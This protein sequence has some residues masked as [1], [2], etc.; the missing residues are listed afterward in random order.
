[1]M[2]TTARL[3]K[4]GK[5]A[6][7][8]LW[9]ETHDEAAFYVATGQTR[10]GERGEALFAGRK[11]TQQPGISANNVK[12]EVNPQI[13]TEAFD[14]SQSYFS[15]L[16]NFQ[17]N[18]NADFE[19]EFGRFA[20]SQNIA[21]GSQAWRRK[22]TDAIRRK[23]FLQL[24]EM[25]FHY[26][27]KVDSDDDDIKEEDEDNLGL[28]RREKERRR[29][30]RVFQNMCREAKLEP[31]ATI[32]GCATNLKS[33]LI[34]IVDYIDAKRS[35]RPIKVWP[36]HEF[37]R[38]RK[39]S[40]SDGKRMDLKEAKRGDGLLVPL[41]QVLS[42]SN[43]ASV[44]QNHRD[45]A[46]VAREH[47]TSRVLDDTNDQK[48]QLRLSAIKEEPDAPHD[49]I[50]IHGTESDRSPSPRPVDEICPWSPSSIGSSVLE[51]A[52]SDQRGI[53]RDLE[54]FTGEQHIS[55]SELVFPSSQKRLRT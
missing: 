12:K 48:T 55:E 29:K 39:Y 2:R 11:R 18:D 10:D 30:L 9:F 21:P 7:E 28:S 49:V 44:Y 17:P 53:K 3:W 5:K 42:R 16:P 33:V 34:N 47:C 25:V 41:L 14:A 43:A 35:G 38:F 6:Q 20:S 24:N 54:D 13:K 36:P 45:R 27:Q 19:D 32:D 23:L 4:D 1:M 26:S 51:I 31:L 50:S 37:E 8:F 15:Q 52:S 46:V 22:R 40:L